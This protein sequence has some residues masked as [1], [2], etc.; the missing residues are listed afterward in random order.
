MH[1]W[2][3]YKK[4]KFLTLQNFPPKNQSKRIKWCEIKGENIIKWK[5]FSEQT[6]KRKTQRN[7][8]KHKIQNLLANFPFEK[9]LYKNQQ[10]FSRPQLR[11]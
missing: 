7:L 9:L 6:N 10:K 2:K 11:K 4:G 3:N 5:I 1:F 8:L